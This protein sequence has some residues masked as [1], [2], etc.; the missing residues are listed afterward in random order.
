MAPQYDAPPRAVLLEQ[1]MALYYLRNRTVEDVPDVGGGI[2]TPLGF[3][4]FCI[5]EAL[6][7]YGRAGALSSVH[8][9]EACHPAAPNCASTAPV[10]TKR[11]KKDEA[12]RSEL[13]PINFAAFH[14]LIDGAICGVR[15]V[16]CDGVWRKEYFAYALDPPRRPAQAATTTRREPE[17]RTRLQCARSDLSVRV[18]EEDSQGGN[19]TVRASRPSRCAS[20]NDP[21]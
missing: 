12:I 3:A 5:F 14:K 2:Q 16:R 6:K 18:G 13:V 4:G 8:P 10:G 19:R 11:F 7:V 21:V 9:G 15:L 1:V 17:H 20:A